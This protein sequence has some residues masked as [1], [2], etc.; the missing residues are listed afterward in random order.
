MAVKKGQLTGKQK[1]FAQVYAKTL[2]GTQSAMQVYQTKAPTVA[3]A[4]ASENLR[5]PLIKS[6]IQRILN[7]RNKSLDHITNNISRIADAKVERPITADQVLKANIEF[8]KLH[9]AY[10]T[11]KTISAKYSYSE[12]YNQ[13]DYQDLEKEVKSLRKL[14]DELN[15]L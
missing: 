4:I 8:L 11:K 15:D 2:N 10:P 13:M 5:K 12:S 7:S 1:V 14:N 9:D 6:E 3:N